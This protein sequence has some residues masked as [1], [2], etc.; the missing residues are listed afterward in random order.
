MH[1]RIY[2]VG[3]EVFN[4]LFSLALTIDTHYES[5]FVQFLNFVATSVTTQ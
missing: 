2:F 4:I 1:V 5:F 3:Q